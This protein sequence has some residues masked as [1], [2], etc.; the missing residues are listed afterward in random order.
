M[1]EQKFEVTIRPADV[2]TDWRGPLA[3]MG[4]V[5]AIILGSIA[6]NIVDKS[7]YSSNRQ[8]TLASLIGLAGLLLAWRWDNL[9]RVIGGCILIAISIGGFLKASRT[10]IMLPE[11]VYCA[12][13]ISEARE[14]FGSEW[15]SRFPEAN[16]KLCA[17]YIEG[18]QKLS[19]GAP[20]VSTADEPDGQF[21]GDTDTIAPAPTPIEENPYATYCLNL[22][23]KAK[24]KRN[25]NWYSAIGDADREKCIREIENQQ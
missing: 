18:G 15:A 22:I 1:S 5:V 8:Y 23:S 3:F 13:L 24:A 2:P 16:R 21:I 14:Q 12:Q 7:G 9:F 6:F 4:L 19:N 11:D 25:E 17:E 10:L 20:S